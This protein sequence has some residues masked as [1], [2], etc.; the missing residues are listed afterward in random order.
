MI[1][2]CLLFMFVC[3]CGFLYLWYFIGYRDFELDKVEM[4]LWTD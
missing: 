3:G 2:A 4:F 1:V